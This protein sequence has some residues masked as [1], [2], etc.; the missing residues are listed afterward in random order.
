MLSLCYVLIFQ[1]LV[2]RLNSKLISTGC[3]CTNL[4]LPCFSFSIMHI[5]KYLVTLQAVLT[6]EHIFF[7]VEIFLHLIFPLISCCMSLN[8][9][10]PSLCTG[11]QIEMDLNMFW[12]GIGRLSYHEYRWGQNNLIFSHLGQIAGLWLGG[13]SLFSLVQV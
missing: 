5:F 12:F 9:R 1:K 13:L 6:S 7:C 11:A 2:V 8:V 3:M 10:V 4:Y